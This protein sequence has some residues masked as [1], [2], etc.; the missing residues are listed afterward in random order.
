MLDAVEKELSGQS[1]Q[2]EAF[3]QLYLPAG[4]ELQLVALVVPYFPFKISS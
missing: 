2:L 3:A 4:Q 1:W